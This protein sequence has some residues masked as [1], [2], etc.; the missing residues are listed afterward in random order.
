MLN[1][2][3]LCQCLL[4]LVT[5]QDTF[6]IQCPR[7]LGINTG[8]SLHILFLC[9]PF[10]LVCWCTAREQGLVSCS[11]PPS[12]D[13]PW[14]GEVERFSVKPRVFLLPAQHAAVLLSLVQPS[15]TWRANSCWT[16]MARRA[17]RQLLRERGVQAEVR[18]PSG[19][20]EG[21]ELGHNSPLRWGFALPENWKPLHGQVGEG[22]EVGG[23]AEGWTESS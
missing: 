5:S 8:S 11:S 19:G 4:Y 22:R 23:S 3:R 21:C 9:G 15:R 16:R 20:W 7:T 12:M 14:P 13:L 2:C 10:S 1:R 17:S 18:E 6:R